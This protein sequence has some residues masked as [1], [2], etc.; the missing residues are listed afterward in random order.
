LIFLGSDNG[1]VLV[2]G[3]TTNGSASTATASLYDPATNT[4]AAT[5]G[6]PTAG[7]FYHSATLL[8]NGKVLIAGG[9]NS[10]TT[11]LSSAELYNPVTN[12]FT[13]TPVMPAV[14]QQHTDTRLAT[15]K[16][17]LV[18][19]FDASAALAT[20]AI[21]DPTANTWSSGT[22]MTSTRKGHETALLSDGTVVAFGGTNGGGTTY[23]TTEETYNPTS[24]T[25]SVVGYGYNY[26]HAF[27]T[28]TT[29][30]NGRVLMAGGYTSG[31]TL[32]GYSEILVN[33]PLNQYDIALFPC[34]GAAYYYSPSS[35]EQRYQ[36][37]LANYANVGDGSLPPTTRTTGSTATIRTT[38]RRSHPR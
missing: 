8:T 13:A 38:F 12:T 7:R 27:H 11:S 14:R 18:G 20:T 15:G 1:K 24:N 35:V 19:G 9:V 37:N 6:A 33:Q 31:G 22:S 4:W 25:W 2:V 32:L 34:P 10:G 16:V 36:T 29:L 17:L 23:R 30:Q 3:G 21:Y 26:T 28:A 5:A